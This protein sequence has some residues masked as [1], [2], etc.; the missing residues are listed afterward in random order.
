MSP[1]TDEFFKFMTEYD[2]F[3]LD[4]KVGKRMGGYTTFFPAYKAPFIFSNFNGTS[5]DIDVLTHEAGHAFQAY[6]ASRTLSIETQCHSTSEINEIHS[7]TMEHFAY[8]WMESFFG[9]KANEYLYTHLV[10]SL[11]TIPY[12][13]SVD[14]FQHRVFEKPT[15]SAMERRQA[16]H[17]IELKYLPWRDYDGNEFLENGGFWM[18]KQHIFLY[19]FYYIEYALAQ[20]CAYQFFIKSRAN[21]DEAWNDY[22]NLCKL[23]GSLGYFD[24]LKEANLKTPFDENNIKQIVN[25]VKDVIDEFEKRI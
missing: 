22:I 24:L 6:L 1:E 5:A 11:C 2:L 10:D 14:E 3:D 21:K 7:M 19:P 4:T 16:W 18:Q 25:D 8:P 15:M 13:V 23:G 9:D 17:Q 20:I 12:L